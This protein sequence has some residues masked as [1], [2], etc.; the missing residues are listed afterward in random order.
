MLRRGLFTTEARRH[1]EERKAR[2]TPKYFQETRSKSKSHLESQVVSTLED[3]IPMTS[4][5]VFLRASVLSRNFPRQKSSRKDT[6]SRISN[7]E[8][9]QRS[10]DRKSAYSPDS[11]PLL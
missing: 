8:N 6:N 2:K 9:R 10:G 7:T 3:S 1:G 5:I 4:R 11:V